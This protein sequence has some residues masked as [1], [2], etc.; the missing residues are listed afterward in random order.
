M[1][2]NLR[3]HDVGDELLS[4]PHHRRGGFVA[5]TF[6]AEDI[7]VGHRVQFPASCFQ[8]QV[9]A[10][11]QPLTNAGFSE[12]ATGTQSGIPGDGEETVGSAFNWY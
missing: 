12:A 7:R 11:S 2:R 9:G 6:D 8:L 5:G 1:R 3:S 4:G 10:M